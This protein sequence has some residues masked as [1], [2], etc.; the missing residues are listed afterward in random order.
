[1]ADAVTEYPCTE[2]GMGRYLMKW[3]LNRKKKN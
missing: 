1:M 2:D 3:V